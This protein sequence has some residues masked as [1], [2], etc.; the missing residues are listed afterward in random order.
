MIY[1]LENEKV[2]I[3]ASTYGGELHSII[4]KEDNIDYLWD[5]NPEGWKYHAPTLFPI[6]GRV[7][8]GRYKVNLKE[9]ELPQH[10]LAR[11]SEFNLLEETKDSIAFQLKYS[12]DTLKKYPF[13]FLL[14]TRYSLENNTV[15]VEYEVEN[16]DD[17]NMYFS[18]GGHPAFRCPLY[19]NENVEDYY[20][21]FSNKETASIK[22]L[23]ENGLI[24]REEKKYLDEDNIIRLDKDTF[25]NDALIFNNLKSNRVSLK[26]TKNSKEV[27][28]DF[29]EFP[30][31]GLWA[32]QNGAR[33][34]C[35]EPWFGHSDY[36]GFDLDFKHKEDIETLEPNK[37][38]KC[39]YTIT[40][41]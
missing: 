5:G 11:I 9:Y 22:V 33:F 4:L 40:I 30:F 24:K 36:E 10:G 2:K 34:V 21:E 3:S 37:V 14:T 28:F 23:N 35:I 16:L 1:G 27:L 15:K 6:V 17:N 8:G 13:K 18:I 7:N 26:S 25:K 39:S 32:P 20:F 31:L 19:E 38:F 12:D 29:S 41:K